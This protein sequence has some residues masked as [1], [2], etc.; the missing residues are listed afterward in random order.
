MTTDNDTTLRELA[1]RANRHGFELHHLPG[2]VFNYQLASAAVTREGVDELLDKLEAPVAGNG[3]RQAGSRE[4]FNKA[5]AGIYRL[6]ALVA[7]LRAADP[8]RVPGDHVER[9][10]AIMEGILSE[11]GELV[12]RL[13][14]AANGGAVQ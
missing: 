3:A 14:S 4:Q 2:H 10:A 13:A 5:I 9:F 1:A 7:V 11:T 8:E 12:D 6:E